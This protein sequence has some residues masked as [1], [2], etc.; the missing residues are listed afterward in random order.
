LPLS[1]NRTSSFA[2][3]LLLLALPASA[4]GNDT[5][6]AAMPEEPE[7]TAVVCEDATAWE[8]ARGA[9]LT[10]QGQ[11][12]AAVD[13][14][15]FLGRSG[16]KD[17]RIARPRHDGDGVLEVVIP[18]DARSGPIEVEGDGGETVTEEKLHVTRGGGPRAAP[19]ADD[20]VFPI[21][22]KHQYGTGTNRFGGGRGHQGQDVF[23][24]CGTP[25][26]AVFDAT[27]QHKAF[28]RR[29]GN[30]VVLQTSDGASFA[31][32]HLQAPSTLKVGALVRAG[33]P[34]GKVGDTG[35]AEGCHLHFEQWT[36]PGWY[37][38]GEA[39]DP[40]PLLTS[41]DK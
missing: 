23:A 37:E 13:T 38:G 27:V 4:A 32:M 25:L 14:V 16:R 3:G 34:V 6:G 26:V 30:Y 19:A 15:R 22:G 40:L 18:R 29:A 21:D 1:L 17:D 41:L 12:L 36:A 2:L 33:D 8:C 10:V 28:Q 24:R 31:Y 39:I 35:H 9:R 5:G 7:V 20:G 11:S